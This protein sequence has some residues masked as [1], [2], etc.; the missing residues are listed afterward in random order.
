MHSQNS[1]L[2]VKIRQIWLDSCHQKR[3]EDDKKFMKFTSNLLINDHDYLVMYFDLVIYFSSK[4]LQILSFDY[5][6]DF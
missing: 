5:A 2:Q 3:L 1:Y 4:Y 6:Y